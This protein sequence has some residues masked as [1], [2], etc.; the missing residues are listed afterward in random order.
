MPETAKPGGQAKDRNQKFNEVSQWSGRVPEPSSLVPRV[1]T[2]RKMELGTEP[3][4][5]FTYPLMGCMHPKNSYYGFLSDT[6]FLIKF[7]FDS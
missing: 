4:L 5:E 7:L 1:Y 3:E 6:S 2:G